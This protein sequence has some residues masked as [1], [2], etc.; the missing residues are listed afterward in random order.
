MQAMTHYD[1]DTL[2]LADNHGV[3]IGRRQTRGIE[4][5]GFQLG[6]N[7]RFACI[8]GHEFSSWLK[9]N[10]P[11]LQSFRR[12]PCRRAFSIARSL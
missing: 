11:P 12:H 6:F 4:P 8:Q 5:L 2:I 1:W 7:S 10:H 9:K 3:D